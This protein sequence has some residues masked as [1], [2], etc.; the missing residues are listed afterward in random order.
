MVKI[1]L[2]KTDPTLEAADRALEQREARIPQRTYLGAS[3]IGGCARK[4]YY[5]FYMCGRAPFNS[6]TLKRF[7]DGHRTEDLLIERLRLVDGVT[8]IDRD[9]DPGRQIQIVDH[10]GHYLGHLD[11][12]ILGILQAPKTWHVFE[13]KAVGDAVFKRL[14]KLQRE[15][16]EKLVLQSWND[17]YYAQAQQYMMYRGRKRHYMVISTAGGRDWT[18][19][20]TNFDREVAESYTERARQIVEEPGILPDKISENAGYWLCNMCEANAVCHDGKAPDRNCRTCVYSKPVED[21]A[22]HCQKHN[23]DIPVEV[24]RTGCPDQRYR[25]VLIPGKVTS[26]DE[27]RN[28]ITYLLNG[29]Y[30]DAKIEW[31][32]EGA[33]DEPVRSE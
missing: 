4:N 11:G 15:M 27:E 29:S 18:S 2:Q 33:T 25:P 3:G 8:L 22:W 12:E 21:A 31:T 20:R 24:Q 1:E 6:I 9:P 10:N 26:V 32:D 17:T 7:A 28:T 23:T 30:A 14:Q 19:I 16:N 5:H 13:A